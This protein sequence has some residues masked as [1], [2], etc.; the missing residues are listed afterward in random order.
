MI[1]N[2]NPMILFPLDKEIH[3]FFSSLNQYYISK[4]IF[5]NP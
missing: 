4:I 5:K 1:Y 2:E 3:H